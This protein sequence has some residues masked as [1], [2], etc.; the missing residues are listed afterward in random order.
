[1]KK[2]IDEEQQ[3]IDNIANQ[4]LFLNNDNI[5]T[6]NIDLSDFAQWLL[7]CK[8]NFVNAT[9]GIKNYLISKGF[10]IGLNKITL[11]KYLQMKKAYN[12]ITTETTNIKF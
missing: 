11:T 2:F 10:I 6:T 5:E 1:M 12:I 9:Q 7:D 8:Y 4:S 3:I